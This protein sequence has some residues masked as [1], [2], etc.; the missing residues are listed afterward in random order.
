MNFLL[1]T[2]VISEPLKP[3]PNMG[4]LVWLSEMDEDR[5]FL[6]VVT[7]MEVRYGIE[8]MAEGAKRKRLERWLQHDLPLRFERRILDV[9]PRIAEVGGRLLARS[10][11]GGRTPKRNDALIAATSEVHDLTLVTR[12]VSDFQFAVSAVLNP[13]S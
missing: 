3:Q 1:D 5:L 8:L 10:E 6:S 2:N 12:N 13:W 7:L 4:V 11:A 9:D